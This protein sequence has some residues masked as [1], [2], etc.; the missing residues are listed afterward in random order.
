MSSVLYG[1]LRIERHIRRRTVSCVDRILRN[2]R[3]EDL[4]VKQPTKFEFN[5]IAD[6]GYTGPR[7]ARMQMIGSPIL[8]SSLHSHV[9]VAPVS[10][11]NIRRMLPDKRGNRLWIGDN[12]VFPFDLPSPVNITDRFRLSVRRPAPHTVPLQPLHDCEARPRRSL[13]S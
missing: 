1:R 2:A 11:R 3:P 8:L 12:Y 6:E 9:D 5:A 13:E 7:L 10:G 4:P